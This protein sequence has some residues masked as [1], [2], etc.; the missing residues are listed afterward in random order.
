MFL[1]QVV[2]IEKQH[3]LCTLKSNTGFLF[4]DVSLFPGIFGAISAFSLYGEYTSYVLSFRM[5]FFYLVTTGWTFLHQ[6]M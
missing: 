5:V 6:L 4:F 1:V 2:T 3:K